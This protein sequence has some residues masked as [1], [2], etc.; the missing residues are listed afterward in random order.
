[1]AEGQPPSGRLSLTLPREQT[2][3]TPQSKVR[4]RATHWEGAEPKVALVLVALVALAVM[5]NMEVVEVQPVEVLPVQN[6]AVL[7]VPLYTEEAVVEE[8]VA[9]VMPLGATMKA[10]HGGHI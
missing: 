1:M 6:R 7:E 9:T 10:A 4:H 2:V 3:A 8:E 5:Q